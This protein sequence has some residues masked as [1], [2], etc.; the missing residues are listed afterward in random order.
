[1][2]DCLINKSK[3][4]DS[5]SGQVEKQKQRS[6]RNCLLLRGISENRNEKTD[7]FCVTVMNEHLELSIT[8]ADIERTHP[9]GK[10]RDAGQKSRPIIF[11]LVGYN[12]RKSIINRKQKLKGKNIAITVSL[13]A[14]RM[15]KLN[16]AREMYDFK[17]VWTSVG[18]I[19]FKKG[20][21]DT[22]LFY[23][24]FIH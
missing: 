5:L 18:D 24:S 23:D 22:S 1:M 17:I 3:Q 20:S 21:G 8:E 15:K 13:R 6:R 16:E 11:K 2:E 9:I 12:D 4:V 14:I 7:D 19:L 10:L